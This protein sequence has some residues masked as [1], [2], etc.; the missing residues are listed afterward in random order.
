MPAIKVATPAVN[1]RQKLQPVMT[2]R[3]TRAV[4]FVWRSAKQCVLT[5]NKTGSNR[6]AITVY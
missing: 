2:Q 5:G 3:M 4:R 6:A 1:S